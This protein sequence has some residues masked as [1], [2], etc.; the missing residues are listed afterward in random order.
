MSEKYEEKLSKAA[1]KASSFMKE[2]AA[3]IRQTSES[4]RKVMKKALS[5]RHNVLMVRINDESLKKIDSLVNAGIF[6]SRSECAAF[7]L[8]EGIKAQSNIFKKIGEKVSQIDQLKEE[9]KNII[10]QEMM[11]QK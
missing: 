9:L 7:L 10:A 3:D 11:D 5:F 8:A 1:G 6:R 4:L 2:A